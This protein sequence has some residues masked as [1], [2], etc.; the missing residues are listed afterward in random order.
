MSLFNFIKT[1]I[2]II[3]VINEYV[4]MKPAGGYLKGP[5]PFHAEKDASF[6][7][8]P[9][10]SIFYCFGCHA[11]GDVIAF[12]AKIENLN[13]F[14]AAVYL[15]EKFN[16]EIPEHIKKSSPSLNENHK[17]EK[18]LYLSTFQ[19]ISDWTSQEL[20]TSI[21]AKEYL[22]KRKI[23]QSDIKHF[24]IG[25]MPGGHKE[26]NR[27]INYMKI[28]GILLKNLI[29]AG[30]IAESGSVFYSPFEE[31][32]IF[33][34]KDALGKICGFGGRIFREK[35]ERAKYYNSKESEVF[36]KG[37]IL[38]GFDLAKKSMHQQKSAF[39]VEGYTDCIAM[40][41]YGYDNTI[42]TLGTACTIDH[43]KLL[44]RHIEVLNVLYDG[45]EAGQNAILRL[46]ELCWEVNLELN[47]IKLPFK[48]DPASF[49]NKG[50]DLKELI[51]KSTDIFSFFI[52]KTSNSFPKLSL[53]EKMNRAKKII[54]L[55]S[56]IEDPL[57]QALLIQMAAANTS[58]PYKTLQS[59]LEKQPSSN[60]KS[61]ETSIDAANYIEYEKELAK[62]PLLEKKIFFAMINNYKNAN[63]YI[64]EK[65]LVQYFSLQMQGLLNKFLI[66]YTPAN[67]EGLSKF[68]ES[69]DDKET[70]W[71]N[72]HLILLNNYDSNETF[73]QL[74]FQ[75]QKQKWR[76][77]VQDIKTEL[78]EAQKEG[79]AEL[80]KQLTNRFLMLKQKIKHEGLL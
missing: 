59:L 12:I 27:F 18:Q 19:A 38:F 26:I 63:N 17:Q 58:I 79:N 56:K 74:L 23:E 68:F 47:I 20:E 29:D 70:A 80:I 28:K 71:V 5:C 10:K 61:E 1:Q 46:T 3:D 30:F 4:V 11:S 14:E 7:I 78:L 32:I 13:Q 64:I 42:A 72:K 24:K 9:E 54:S 34:I 33:P 21:I 22:F 50:G 31:R 75:F 57:K 2:P 6:T 69:L 44:S 37:K 15:T 41:K 8:S 60:S 62:I 73:E 51:K 53:A 66:A 55:I 65:E 76:K 77:I 49:L 52:E 40:V 39:L 45:D 35:D 67:P 25:Y 36:V 16:I 43:L 48:E